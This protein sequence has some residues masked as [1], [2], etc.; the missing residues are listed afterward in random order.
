MLQSVFMV[1]PSI[2][3]NAF[4]IIKMKKILSSKLVGTVAKPG[5]GLILQ[6]RAEDLCYFLGQ[7]PQSEVAGVLRNRV[8]PFSL[9]V[10]RRQTKKFQVYL[11]ITQVIHRTG[12]IPVNCRNK[13]LHHPWADKLS[14]QT[15]GRPSLRCWPKG[16][17][18][19]NC[20]EGTHGKELPHAEQHW[21]N[22]SSYLSLQMDGLEP[23]AEGSEIRFIHVSSTEVMVLWLDLL[24][25]EG[26]L[27]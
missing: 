4:D 15:L 18:Q 16:Q 8:P 9:H 23:N 2:L 3:W 19:N 13:T 26:K 25:L 6:S 5:Q 20:W 17:N 11:C 1:E 7:V 21:E 14:C 22:R 24:A 27:L 10:A 12:A